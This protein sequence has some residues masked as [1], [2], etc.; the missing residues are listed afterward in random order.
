MRTELRK[1][2]P[3]HC[4]SLTFRPRLIVRPY[5]KPPRQCGTSPVQPANHF[6]QVTSPSIRLADDV[7][8][9]SIIGNPNKGNGIHASSK[10]RGLARRSGQ[11]DTPEISLPGLFDTTHYWTALATFPQPYCFQ[12]GVLVT[13]SVRIRIR[14]G[15]IWFSTENRTV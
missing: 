10:G 9:I 2:Y 15:R 13:I 8:R 5:S 14:T 12:I 11:R 4:M 3:R 7:N 1:P 6:S